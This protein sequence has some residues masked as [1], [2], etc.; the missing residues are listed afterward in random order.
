MNEVPL[1]QYDLS[2]YVKQLEIPNFV[3]VY[4][5][6]VLPKNPKEI[7]C[8]ILNLDTISNP[9][10]HWV[11]FMKTCDELCLYF[12]SF[13]VTPPIEFEE[14]MKCDI[15]YSTYQIQKLNQVICGHLCLLVLFAVMKLKLDFHTVVLKLFLHYNKCP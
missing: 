1:T 2:N 4:M 15:L 14:Y 5:R 11:C 7:E 3:G 13:G 10:T 12:D 8:G 9:G 6:D